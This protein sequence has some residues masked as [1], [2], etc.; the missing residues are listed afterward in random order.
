MNLPLEQRTNFRLIEEMM[1]KRV[2]EINNNKYDDYLGITFTRMGNIFD[3][4]R[5]FLSHYYT[6]GIIGL[7]IFLFPYIIIVLI[8]I[9]KILISIKQNLNLKNTCYLMGIGITLFAAAFTG[10]VMDGLIV[11][12]ILGFFIGQLINNVFHIPKIKVKNE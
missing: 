11:T 7:I 5:D 9:I 4:E 1:L 3:L 6:L 2:K 8:C 12:L 10:N